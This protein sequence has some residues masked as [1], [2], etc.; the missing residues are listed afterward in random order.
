MEQGLWSPDREGYVQHFLVSGPCVS[1][2]SRSERDTNQLRYEGWLRSI[3]AEHEPVRDAD[4]FSPRRP[5]RLG[6]PWRFYGGRDCS[7]VNL[8]EFYPSMQR[9]RFDAV[10]VLIAPDSMDLP[11]RVWSYAAVDLYCGGRLI[12]GLKQPV[13]KPISSETLT[14][15]LH[16]GR[17]VIYLACETLGVRDTRSV[18]ALQL[19]SRADEIRVTLPDAGLAAEAAEALSFLEGTTLSDDSLF[20]PFP[21]PA[22]SRWTDRTFGPDFA[23][24]RLPTVWQDLGGSVSLRVPPSGTLITLSVPLASGFLSRAFEVTE[25]IQPRRIL[26]TPSHEENLS[27]IWRRIAA[28]DSLSRGEEFGFPI[29]NM[30]VRRFLGDASHDDA[31]HMDEMLSLIERRVDC[32]DFLVCGLIRYVKSYPVQQDVAERI[33]SVLTSWR[34]WMDQDGFDGMCF[35]SENHALMFYSCA[36]FVGQMYP[37]SFFPLACRSG[38]ELSAWGRRNVLAWL[39]DVERFGFE[40]FLSTVYMCVTFAALLNLVDYGDGEI[41]ARAGKITDR[42]LEM[43]ALHTF[44]G[45]IIAP[46]GRIYRNVL[47]P[48]QAGAM[49]LMNLADP[50]QP[51]DY[52]EGWLGFYATSRYVFPASLPRLMADPASLS[53]VTGNARI[54]LEKH[55]DWCLTSVQSPREPFERWPNEAILPSADSSSHAFVKSFNECFHGTTHFQ[56]GVFGYQQHLWYAALDGSAAIFVNHPGSVSEGGDMRPGYWHGNGVFPALRQDKNLLGFIYRIPETHPIHFI[57]LYAPLCRFDE[58]RKENNWLFL[59]R[60]DGYIGFWSNLPLEPWNNMNFDCE[61]R[62]WGSDIAGLCLCAGR[63]TASMDAFVRLA[64]DLNPVY[65]ASAATLTAGAFTLT[66]VPGHDETQYL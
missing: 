2:F 5:G 50:A 33:Q 31:R 39:E 9:V 54:V 25:H 45:G 59:R 26:P 1:P 14:L 55:P 64:A 43:L 8:S 17:N 18:V 24:N 13:Y 34:Y 38:R 11:V 52:G 44:R 57:H 46:Q 37:D 6:L 15:P 4:G 41:S 20:F 58:V 27:L 48:F 7:F 53:Y 19:L 47:Y 35:W 61:Q 63:E 60:G 51:F 42:L 40:E 29:A 10:T 66:W 32:A 16:P 62:L 49:A 23:E 12:G 36:L 3:V 30:L 56:P 21:A 28:V 65:D 22:G